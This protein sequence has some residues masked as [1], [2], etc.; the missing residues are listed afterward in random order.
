MR[1]C[2]HA[3][4]GRR[5]LNGVDRLAER[6][7]GRQIE[8]QRHRRELP[9][10]GDQQRS[11]VVGVDADERGERNELPVGRRLDV[12]LVERLHALLQFGQH[13]EHEVIGI[14][15]EILR[16]L[17]LAERVVE[18]VVD[19]LRLDAEAGRRI[20]IDGDREQ[21]RFV[22]RVAGD[23][24]QLRQR[25]ELGEQARSPGIQLVQIGI[26]QHVLELA[27][28]DA[29]ADGDVLRRLQEEPSRPGLWRAAAAAGR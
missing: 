21:R 19:E 16:H 10:M 22:L 23:V 7:A 12:D 13:L 24:G 14:V 1:D 3:D 8:G 28:R 4:L 15:G 9:G 6:H 29:A 17:A 25:F 5:L 2:R 26:L 18:R 27:A 11:N 20:A